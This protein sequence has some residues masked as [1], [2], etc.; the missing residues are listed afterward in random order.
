MSLPIV[1][2]VGRTN[3]GKSSLF[4]RFLRKR[5]AVVDPEPGVTRD[6]N[7]AVCDWNGREFRLIDTGGMEPGTRD[8]MEKAIMDQSDFAIHE[9]DLILLVVD[10][11]VGPDQ[12]DERL[13][14]I[15][16]QSGK[17]CVLIANKADDDI[18]EN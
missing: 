8:V 9:A 4:N 12:I 17:P 15:L 2:I 3:V 13:A 14:R 7:Y 11:K 10:V 18:L 16:H 6:R 1:A 5:L